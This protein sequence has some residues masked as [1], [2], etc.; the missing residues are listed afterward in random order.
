MCCIYHKPRAVGESSSES[1]SPESDSDTDSDV[2][3]GEARMANN[4]S[5]NRH[6]HHGQGHD[7]SSGHSRKPAKR[8]PK[9]NAYERVPKYDTKKAEDTQV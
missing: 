8:K 6:M 1:D 4:R 5:Q 3:N 9:V 2:D 7:D